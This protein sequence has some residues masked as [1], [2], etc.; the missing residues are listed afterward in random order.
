MA[1]RLLTTPGKAHELHDDLESLW[2]VILYE[3]LHFIQHNKPPKI[4]MKTLFDQVDLCD[5]T[6]THT[7]GLG[8]THLYTN[9]C[10]VMTSQ[11][12]F[13]SAPF[14]T[15]VRQ[16]YLLFRALNAYYMELDSGVNPEE[17]PDSRIVKSVR[18]LD[19][20]AE[21]ERLLREALGSKGWPESCDKVEDQYPPRK[22]LTAKQKET[23]ALSYL[24]YPCREPGE[25]SGVKRKLEEEDPPA[26]ENKRIKIEPLWKRA[27][28]KCVR[29]VQS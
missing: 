13:G 10:I 11:L 22:L 17:D 26:F 1:T 5:A 8:K 15:L 3:A 9:G 25:T 4:N 29:L 12:A 24:N 6:G 16:I 21:I 28:S 27:W 2:F 14:T 19:S 7:G 20:C 23:I 18:K